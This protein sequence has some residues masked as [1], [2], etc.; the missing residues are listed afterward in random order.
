MDIT[1]SKY[2]L[3]PEIKP[4]ASGMLDLD[5]HHRMY[6]EV[7]GNPDGAPVAFL[8]GGPGA[9]TSPTYRRFFDPD[10]YRIILFDQR[11]AGKSK[12][13][14]EIKNN[15]TQDLI[16]DM[17]K[18]RR[19]LD[20]GTWLLFG[21]SW[22]SSLGLAYAITHPGRVSGLILRGIFLCRKTELDW[23]M[24]GVARIFPEAWR[25]FIAFLPAAER[26]DPLGAY[27]ARLTHPEPAVHAP[28]ARVWT[29]FEGACSTLLP[30]ARAGGGGGLI[31]QTGPTALALARIE[32]HYFVNRMFL[33]EDYFFANLDR[34]R[35]LPAVL[36]QGRYDMVCP[37]ATADLLAG[38]WPEADYVVVPGAGHS[39]LE[40]AIRSSLVAATEKFK[41]RG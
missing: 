24:G 35:H 26:A 41:E 11:G 30:S 31:S 36:V 14:G 3:F 38:A 13:F 18:L 4:H 20:I 29:R 32:V 27:H 23:F 22:G 9:G 21:G 16:E 8:H 17:E 19:Q 33:A 2:Q 6:W 5:G 7:S 39:A 1:D 34:I 25:D 10:H 37:I 12:P 28:A 15:T 40:P